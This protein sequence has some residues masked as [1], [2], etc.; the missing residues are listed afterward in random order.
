MITEVGI[1]KYHETFQDYAVWYWFSFENVLQRQVFYVSTAHA[2]TLCNWVK[3][4]IFVSRMTESIDTGNSNL[5]KSNKVDILE[6]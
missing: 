1:I 5:K 2:Q 4:F 6:I 3:S